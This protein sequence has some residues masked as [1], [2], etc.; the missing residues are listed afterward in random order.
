MN[1][2]RLDSGDDH[3]YQAHLLPAHDQ[4]QPQHPPPSYPQH[5]RAVASPPAAYT[6][7]VQPFTSQPAVFPPAAFQSGSLPSSEYRVPAPLVLHPGVPGHLHPGLWS[8]SIWDCFDSCVI[9]LLAL[10]LP[11]LRWA[12]TVSRVSLLPFP[13]ALLLHG[14]PYVAYTVLFCYMNVRYPSTYGTDA[15]PEVTGAYIALLVMLVVMHLA[16]V[17]VGA[18]ARGRLRKRYG[19]SGAISQEARHVDR[20]YGLPV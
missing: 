17:A 1:Y 9:C 8:D 18:W 7:P 12:L 6:Q 19:I 10:F 2:N 14:V 11:S 20:D 13:T 4:Q 15:N 3:Q 5:L 16:F